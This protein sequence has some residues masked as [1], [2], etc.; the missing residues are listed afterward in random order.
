[1]AAPDGTT[2]SANGTITG[3]QP[4]TRAQ[5][6]DMAN[7]AY[8]PPAAI[9]GYTQIDINGD[10]NYKRDGQNLNGFL[11]SAYENGNQIVVTFRGTFPEPSWNL[12][13]NLVADASWATG[14]PTQTLLNDIQQADAFLALV[15]RQHPNATI[16]VTGH[17]LGGALAQLVGNASGY[18]T[19]AFNAPGTA[20]LAQN[21]SVQAKLSGSA[22]IKADNSVGTM[23]SQGANS[24]YRMTGDQVS[25]SGPALNNNVYTVPSPYPGDYPDLLNN[26]SMV[27]MDNQLNDVTVTPTKSVPDPQFAALT[28]GQPVTQ[29]L[30]TLASYSFV[31][32]VSAAKVND[33]LDPAPGSDYTLLQDAASPTMASITL[34]DESANGV[35]QSAVASYSNGGWSAYT[36]VAPNTEFDFATPAIGFDI[37]PLDASGNPTA[38][39]DNIIFGIKYTA[40]GTVTAAMNVAAPDPS[41]VTAQLM[42]T[43]DLTNPALGQYILQD[44]QPQF[45]AVGNPAAGSAGRGLLDALD[46]GLNI[47]AASDNQL[48]GTVTTDE[49]NS[50]A[51]YSTNAAEF[52]VNSEADGFAFLAGLANPTPFTG[53]RSDAS[54]IA[55]LQGAAATTPA[56]ATM[57]NSLNQDANMFIAD[58]TADLKG[59]SIA[60]ATAVQTAIAHAMTNFS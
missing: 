9:D 6:A 15:H 49:S 60:Q 39:N 47:R 40:A 8:A 35:T 59:G 28:V 38:L 18:T 23:L 51:T 45:A 5:I 29:A 13:K 22:A 48:A 32:Q 46:V 7:A 33:W 42:D 34:P 20:A 3:A 16:T 27:T 41:T 12:V 2:S 50:L 26:H 1:V 4:P 43:V 31:F 17:S 55:F 30:A 54:L 21:A 25:L 10:V 19:D 24:N 36:T 57:L 53:A 11:G 58:Y 56:V 14:T 37:K 44:A 52:A